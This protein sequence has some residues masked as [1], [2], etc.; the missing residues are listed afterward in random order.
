MTLETLFIQYRAPIIFVMLITPWLSYLICH[1]IPGKSEEPY[2]LSGNLA[3]SVLGILCL[4]GYLAYASNTGGWQLVVKQADVFLLLIVPYHVISSLCLAKQRLPLAE[5]PAFRIMQGLVMIGAIY[6]V[7][8]WLA[9]RIYIVF[10]SYMPF[11]SFLVVLAI[12]LGIA[13]SGYLKV[14]DK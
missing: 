3:L 11:S 6:V 12:L 9:S 13:Y 10:F 4:S 5:I 2:V 14:F 1:F 8:S 7:L